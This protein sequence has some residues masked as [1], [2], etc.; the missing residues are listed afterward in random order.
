VYAKEH[1]M[2]TLILPGVFL[3]VAADARKDDPAKKDLE[4]LQ[5]TWTAVV[6]ERNGQ[7]APKE[8]LQ[9]FTVV[10][11]GNKM[12]INPNSDNR[13]ST[14]KLDPTKKPKWMDNSPEQGPAKE[15]SL[16]AIYELDGDTV[17]ICFDNEGVSDKRPSE[18]KT[19][20]GSGRALF[21]LKRQKK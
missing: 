12:I 14:F 5:G 1:V 7:M 9:D 19:T 17:K 8:V 13:T 3:L 11:E 15:K 6:V 20:P 10:F 16:P 4:A 18:F 2:T 21:V